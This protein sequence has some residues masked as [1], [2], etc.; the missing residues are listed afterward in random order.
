MRDQAHGGLGVL[1]VLEDPEA[2]GD[3][4]HAAAVGTRGVRERYV[5]GQ[6]LFLGLL[7]LGV[8]GLGE[9][10]LQREGDAGTVG[11]LGD[12]LGDEVLVVAGPRPGQGVGG[13]EALLVNV[14]RPLHYLL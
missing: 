2:H 7:V 9:R 14:G 13:L 12:V 8:G 10:V 4:P 3:R 1:A 6:R 5:I 11:G